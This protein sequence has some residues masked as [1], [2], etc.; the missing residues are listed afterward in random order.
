MKRF[1]PVLVGVALL[2]GC[3]YYNAMYNARR[4]SDDAVKA[5]SEGRNFDAS[6]IWGQVT[7]KA[8]TVIARHPDSKYAPE[9]YALMGRAH[10]RL[11]NCT[12]ARPALESALA[13]KLDSA[14]ALDT[15]LRLAGCY[16]DLG[17]HQ[18]AIL[19]FERLVAIGD[20]GLQRAARAGLI[21]S[22]RVAGRTEDAVGIIEP[23]LGGGPT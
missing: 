2:S 18:D 20:S 3:A 19:R 7:V 21:R 17:L 14:L 23:V 6:T 11:G 4:L 13:S 12:R 5:E 10:A 8:E 9:A 15:E 22:L 1:L 16:A